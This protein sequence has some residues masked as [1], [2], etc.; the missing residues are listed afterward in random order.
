MSHTRSNQKY[1]LPINP[2]YKP[3]TTKGEFEEMPYI[4]RLRL[5]TE[6]PKLYD[7][8]A[9]T[10]SKT[11]FQVE[12][13]VTAMNTEL[14][15]TEEMAQAMKEKPNRKIYKAESD[16]L[17]AE[18]LMSDIDNKATLL[19][20]S[21]DRGQ[22]NLHDLSE[23]TERTFQYLAACKSASAY[24]SVMG[25]SALAF[26]YSTQGLNKFLRE[27]PNS[28]TAEFIELTK[29]TFADILA[30]QALLRNADSTQAIFQLKNQNNFADRV[31]IAP[32]MPSG[33]LG[34]VVDA[35]TIAAK[36]ADLP[37]D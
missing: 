21:A 35:E 9:N 30:N 31:E 17:K 28:R 10:N 7:R 2:A 29:T 26:G 34:E 8:F 32:V 4:D 3:P 19:K 12:T 11:L 24:P 1:E 5:K 6:N 20:L 14:M 23:V 13:E 25:L 15:N 18:A 22:V 37:E 33:P 36:Y 27:N 16:E